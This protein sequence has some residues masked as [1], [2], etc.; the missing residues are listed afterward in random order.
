MEWTRMPSRYLAHGFEK[1][2]QKLRILEATHWRG[3]GSIRVGCNTIA[4]SSSSAA[5][6]CA[7][8]TF[9]WWP[10]HVFCPSFLL[11]FVLPVD[12]QWRR[13][14]QQ[15]RPPQHVPKP[16]NAICWT[17]IISALNMRYSL[18]LTYK[19]TYEGN[20]YSVSEHLVKSTASMEKQSN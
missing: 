5:A 14:Q 8:F 13:R 1:W 15:Q 6:A 12:E 18:V 9:C 16:A 7:S 4:S 3:C 19:P 11:Y 17:C 2:S 20:P 10:Q